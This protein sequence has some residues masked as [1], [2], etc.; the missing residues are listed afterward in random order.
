MAGVDLDAFLTPVKQDQPCGPDLDLEGDL[1]FM[2]YMARAEGLLPETFFSFDRNSIE[3]AKEF[4]QIGEL[5]ELTRDLRLI[6]LYAKLSI[7]NRDTSSFA[8]AMTTAAAALA[9]WWDDIHPRGEDG[10]FMMRVATL[11]SL[12]DTPHV[13]L[14]LQSSPLIDNRRYGAVTFRSWQISNGSLQPRDSEQTPDPS[15]IERALLESDIEGIIARR[16]EL[17]SISQSCQ[18]IAKVS[19]DKGG[20]DNQITLDK[21]QSVSTDIAAMLDHHVATR[22][23]SRAL[24]P[25]GASAEAEAE[26]AG[27]AGAAVVP[28]GPASTIPA[29]IASRR[30]ATRALAAAAEYFAAYEPSSP[31]LMLVRYAEKLMGKSFFEVVR[32]LVPDFASRAA[33]SFGQNSVRLSVGQVADNIGYSSDYSSNDG[34]SGEEGDEN[35]T[36]IVIHSRRD[37]MKVLDLVVTYFR[38]TEPASPIPLIV[39]RAREVGE[40]DF[41]NLLKDLFNEQTLKSIRG[42][43]SY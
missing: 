38:T 10:D 2:N 17:L 11:Q 43:D 5:C 16:D 40:R 1:Q 36:P 12:D 19:A 3:Y 35:P 39:S 29:A 34:A 27:D 41:L 28:S 25:L 42:E 32:A 33:I 4:D 21:L 24:G 23:P 18:A 9:V 37:A 26:S 20:Y 15:T 6:V 31:A 13:I 30:D 14:P 22:D 8:K 7:L